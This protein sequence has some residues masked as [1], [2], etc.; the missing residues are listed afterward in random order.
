MQHTIVYEIVLICFLLWH[1]FIPGCLSLD[2]EICVMK[3]TVVYVDMSRKL[4]TYLL[5]VNICAL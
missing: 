2:I 5:T 1:E 4:L 3:T